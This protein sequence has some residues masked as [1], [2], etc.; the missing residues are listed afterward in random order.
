MTHTFKSLKSGQIEGKVREI[1][2][3]QGTATFLRGETMRQKQPVCSI[4]KHYIHFIKAY[5]LYFSK[6]YESKAE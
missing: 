5:L 1:I 6:L 4:Q 3:K 2:G